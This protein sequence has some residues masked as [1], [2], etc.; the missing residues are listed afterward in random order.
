MNDI[1]SYRTQA[2]F[3]ARKNTHFDVPQNLT[4]SG[5]LLVWCTLRSIFKSDPGKIVWRLAHLPP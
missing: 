3:Q 5:N 4:A 2:T 1:A